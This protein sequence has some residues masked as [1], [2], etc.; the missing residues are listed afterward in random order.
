MELVTKAEARAQ[1]RLDDFDSAGGPDDLW[2]DIWIP[3]VSE[4]VATWLKDD[5]RLY[6]LLRDSAG[7]TIL[8]SSGDP[9]VELDAQ[10]DPIVRKQ[11]KGAVLIELASQFRFREGEGENVVPEH[12][13]HG[14]TL[15]KGATAL[16]SS[17]RKSTVA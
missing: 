10:G 1:L 2:L 13:G 12:E 16:L 4:A 17:L 5:W 11:V 14:Y 8:D 6:V 9:E 7:D 15:S 3:A